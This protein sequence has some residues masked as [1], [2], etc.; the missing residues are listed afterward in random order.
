MGGRRDSNAQPPGPQPGALPIELRPPCPRWESNPDLRLRRPVLYPL[1][2]GDFRSAPWRYRASA[3]LSIGEKPRFRGGNSPLHGV[4]SSLRRDRPHCHPSS[5]Y[6]HLQFEICNC[7]IDCVP[8]TH[9]L[10]LGGI[11]LINYF[12]LPSFLFLVN[13]TKRI[14]P[15]NTRFWLAD[16]SRVFN[17][18]HFSNQCNFNFSWIL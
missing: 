14:C 2:Y 1:S 8:L 10:S 17:H 3:P 7:E 15:P 6:C 13:C 11:L 4:R 18:F 12:Y 16:S 9:S 5:L